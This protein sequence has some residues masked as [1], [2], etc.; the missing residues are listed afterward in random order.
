M[1][2]SQPVPVQA[3]A[4]HRQRVIRKGKTTEV[5]SGVLRRGTQETSGTGYSLSVSWGL[6]LR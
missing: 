4:N 5:E 3:D 2:N 1:N 6:T